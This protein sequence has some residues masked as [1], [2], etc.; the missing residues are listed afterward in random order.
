MRVLDIGTQLFETG[1]QL[2]VIESCLLSREDLFAG[3]VE[4]AVN[5]YLRL[6]SQG[7]GIDDILP[8]GGNL[9]FPAEHFI[10]G[11]S[12][13][14]DTGPSQPQMSLGQTQIVPLYSLHRLGP[15]HVQ[16][17]LRSFQDHVQ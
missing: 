7:V 13:Q 4:D 9:T 16:V 1:D 5:R 12:P 14:L 11:R 2:R 10:S 17:A 8:I 6:V 3:P 15:Q